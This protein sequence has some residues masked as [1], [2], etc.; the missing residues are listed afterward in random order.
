MGVFAIALHDG[1]WYVIVWFQ[2]MI[3]FQADNI[4]WPVYL[5][6]TLRAARFFA[7]RYKYRHKQWYKCRC[8]Y[9]YKYRYDFIYYSHYGHGFLLCTWKI[10]GNR[11]LV[12]HS[13]QIQTQLQTLIRIQ[14]QIHIQ[15]LIQNQILIW[16]PIAR[17]ARLSNWRKRD[18]RFF[19]GVSSC[20]IWLPGK[21]GTFETWGM[22]QFLSA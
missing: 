11:T 20:N 6:C 1:P 9:I 7:G 19:P 17:C 13:R 14:T 4:L 21:I 18:W 3:F 15:M 22:L 5:L 16:F 12:F 2:K 10:D 8:R